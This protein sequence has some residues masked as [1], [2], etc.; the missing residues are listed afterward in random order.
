MDIIG[1][2]FQ[3]ACQEAKISYFACI[4]TLKLEEHNRP[5]SSK[6]TQ[7]ILYILKSFL[8]TGLAWLSK[9]V[10]TETYFTWNSRCKL[11]WIK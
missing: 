4:Y 1:L 8:L 9:L 11:V 10:R 7:C 6:L 2:Y 5:N 3:N